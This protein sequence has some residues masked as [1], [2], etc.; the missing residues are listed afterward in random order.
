MKP[1]VLGLIAAMTINYAAI[2]QEDK[3][4][5]KNEKL[6]KSISLGTDGIR[7]E[8]GNTKVKADKA[9]D[10]TFCGVDLGFNAIQDNTNYTTALTS[11]GLFVPTSSANSGLFDL[12][13]GK[14]INVNLWP[15]LGKARILKTKNQK[16]YFSTGVGLQIYNFRYSNSLRYSDSGKSHISLDNSIKYEKNK[17]TIN[18]LSVPINFTFKTKMANK[19]WLVYGV[20]ITGGFRINSYTKLKSDQYGKQKDHADFDLN[21]FNST[22]TAEFGLDNYFRLYASYQLTNMYQTKTGLDQHPFCIG[23]RFGGI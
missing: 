21:P 11:G 20:G 22:V 16:I 2:A 10:V 18:Y 7:V 3:K 5:E 15:I 9:I 17:L 19:L 14:S 1:I 12:R 8:S 23:L 4:D 6:Q 13:T